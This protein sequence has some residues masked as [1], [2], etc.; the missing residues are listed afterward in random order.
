MYDPVV[1]STIFTVYDPGPRHL[2]VAGN[3]DHAWV[4]EVPPIGKPVRLRATV[5]V[6][7]GG[8]SVRV[9]GDLPP[10]LC[11]TLAAAF[12]RELRDSGLARPERG[13]RYRTGSFVALDRDEALRLADF[14]NTPREQ[15]EVDDAEIVHSTPCWTW[16]SDHVLTHSVGLPRWT[17]EV[18]SLPPVACE[19]IS[20]VVL[21]R[22]RAR[23]PRPPACGFELLSRVSSLV[24]AV[25]LCEEETHSVERFDV[26]VGDGTMTLWMVS[27]SSP[28][29][30][31]IHARPIF[32]L[33]EMLSEALR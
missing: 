14:D 1:R 31:D 27:R 5:E 13:R 8:D 29:L 32:R 6:K 28:A 24:R 3:T 30:V 4:E 15:V 11:R 2:R 20:S 9:D 17:L 16:W 12:R 26:R 21:G 33:S 18:R 23:D 7:E 25:T 22:G 19:L 10:P